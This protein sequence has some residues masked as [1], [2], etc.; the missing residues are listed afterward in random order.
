MHAAIL[1]LA[2]GLIIA[3]WMYRNYV[4]FADPSLAHNSSNM[5]L[6]SRVAYNGMSFSEWTASLLFWQPGL[7]ENF[8]V[9]FFPAETIGRLSNASHANSILVND[10]HHIFKSAIDRNNPSAQF[11]TIFHAHILGDARRYAATALPLFLRSFWGTGSLIGIFGVFFLWPLF[12]RLRHTENISAFM[13]LFASL[14]G[15]VLAQALLTP[16]YPFFNEHMIFIHS[17]AIA[18]VTG[19]LE[20][21]PIIRNLGQSGSS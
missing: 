8:A 4:Y 1:L 20:L 9:M 7:G 5:L 12:R 18:H 2:A 15:C 21:A 17:Y 13:L 11:V 16:S 3:P 19:E 6:A 10:A 14:A